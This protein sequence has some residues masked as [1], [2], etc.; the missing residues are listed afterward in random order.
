MKM[1]Y[2]KQYMLCHIFTRTKSRKRDNRKDI[3]Y[4]LQYAERNGWIQRIV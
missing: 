2:I 1:L 3:K 4:M